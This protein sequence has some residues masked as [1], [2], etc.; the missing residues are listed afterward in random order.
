MA[1][2]LSQQ[3][4]SANCR[5]HGHYQ[6]YNEPQQTEQKQRKKQ[7][8]RRGVIQVRSNYKKLNEEMMRE[9]YFKLTHLEL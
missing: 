3:L 7:P 6:G 5:A 9:V 8:G 2:V 4:V 1:L